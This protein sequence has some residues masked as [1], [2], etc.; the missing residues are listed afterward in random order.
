[1]APTSLKYCAASGGY[2]PAGILKRRLLR[3]FLAMP[4]FGADNQL[5][6]DQR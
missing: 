5:I 4:F 2:F 3:A 1:M 6:A